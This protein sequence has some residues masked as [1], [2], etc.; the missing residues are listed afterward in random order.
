M[1][2]A[3]TALTIPDA[4]L[5]SMGQTMVAVLSPD[6]E[7]ET[8]ALSA[9]AGRLSAGAPAILCH[10]PATAAR[11]GIDRMPWFD[12]LELFAFVHPAA[13]CVPTP[14]GLAAACGV[15][16]PADLES[17]PLALRRAM[18]AMLETLAGGRQDPHTRRIAW[19]MAQAGW[20][21]G[22]SV[23]SSLGT[24]LDDAGARAGTAGLDVWRRLPEWE[25]QAPPP[26]PGA[27]PVDPS[28]ARA[29][30]AFLLG[31]D[32]EARPSQADY[33][34]AVTAAF[35]PPDMEGAPLA[36]LAEAGT[37][38]G[39]TLG[40]IAP[41][42]LW[43]EKNDGPVWL[44]TFTRNLQ[45]Q[46]DGE[47]DRLYPDARIKSDRVVLRKGREN[48]LCLLNFEEAVG[49]SRA[50]PLDAV[51]LGLMARWLDRTRSGDLSGGDFPSW[52]PD[53][54]GRGATLALSDHQG[55]CIY[56]ACAHYGRCFIEN[57]VR[58]A[59]RAS[60]VVA[61]HALVM[62]QSAR[63]T[64]DPAG[65]VGRFVFDEGHHVFDA[66][67]S[68]FSAHLTGWETAELR[69]WLRGAESRRRGRG[70]RERLGDLIDGDD[71]A[72]GLLEEVL[73]A[74]A[75]LPAAGW[76][77]RLR[78][79]DGNGTTEAFLGLVRQQVY[80]RAP[81]RE[82]PFDLEVETTDPVPGLA[83][84]A[85]ALAAAFA[86]LA[87][88]VKGLR[89][90]LSARLEEEA[91]SLDTATRNR[92]DA[93]ARSLQH[94]AH[95]P[96]S[97]W[98]GMLAALTDGTPE[99][100]ADWFQVS[101]I[102]V[103]DI[104]VGLHRH[105]IDPGRPFAEVMSARVQGMVITSAILTDG[106]GDIEAD[107]QAA[108]RRTGAVHLPLPAIRA[109]VPS[110]FDYAGQTRVFIV[111]DVRKDDL[112]QVAAAYRSLFLAAGGGA[113]GL[114]TAI[115]RLRAV[116]RRLT[117]AVEQAGLPL[118]AQHVDALNLP[119][120][121][122]IFR[123]E[124]DSCL[125]GTDAVRDGV[126]VPGRSLRLIVFDRVP[127]PRPTILHK[128]RRSAFGGR[129]YDD[130]LTRLKLKQAYGRLIRRADDRGV[131]VL[132]DPMMPSRLLCAFPEGVEAARVGLA[133]AVEETCRFLEGPG[134]VQRPASSPIS[135]DE[136][137]ARS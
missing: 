120:L 131:F 20:P 57:S 63:G 81:G 76:A 60:L 94:R 56:S 84:A 1:P 103:R 36:V 24:D 89:R 19:S 16:E 111:G 18:I 106:S 66:A 72:V 69:R 112:D 5:I 116:H 121:I 91:D 133:E 137:D 37:G 67:D 115:G 99:D 61:N 136:T 92:L 40:Y 13:F 12:L 7:S 71:T 113:L 44:S 41:A 122:D 107:W 46:I 97:A 123:A 119:T 28:E 73:R 48:Y 14:R 68:A 104:D 22:V 47:L 87:E 77:N 15:P 100:F 95:D 39:K 83:H 130:M 90:R 23:L 118:Y 86:R 59:R 96:L 65:R 10:G 31:G 32:A 45:H 11:L 85:E 109:R 64:L 134:P 43:A 26:P 21:W 54:M 53:L 62:V 38:V 3:Q 33:A 6:G 17:A 75:A 124:P 55:E 25:E 51:A 4:P 132:L 27:A 34:S 50:N 127:W 2:N 108:E 114:F 74:A 101:R 129:G 125:L 93:L 58:Q 79:G 126:D 9:A 88:P 105:W 135:G 70:L 117:E 8:I 42:S 49:R 29:R 128:R 30:L 35:A 98:R 80:A 110:P 102:D 82:G 52:L 78:E